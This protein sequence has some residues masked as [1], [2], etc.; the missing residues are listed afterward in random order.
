MIL[1]VD[2][3]LG[4]IILV[5]VLNKIW[6]FVE[7]KG[8]SP[9]T[10]LII[11]FFSFGCSHILLGLLYIYSGFELLFHM[12]IVALEDSICTI[13]IIVVMKISERG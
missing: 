10:F 13:F 1:L 3:I 6:P 4:L 2:F 7:M 9:E 8:I 12:C 5:F 11:L